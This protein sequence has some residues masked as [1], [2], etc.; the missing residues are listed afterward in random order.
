MESVKNQ[1]LGASGLPILALRA[2]NRGPPAQSNPDCP[3]IGEAEAVDQTFLGYDEDGDLVTVPM[4][5]IIPPPSNADSQAVPKRGKQSLSE[6]R[7]QAAIN[8]LGGLDEQSPGA[9]HSP[10]TVIARVGDDFAK[11]QLNADSLRKKVKEALEHLVD[12]GAAETN[13]TGYRILC[14]LIDHDPKGEEISAP[15]H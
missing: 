1:G 14:G 12:Q 4:A 9:F 15:F 11:G 10:A 8:A 7:A 6:R 2:R 13:G 5:R 3:E